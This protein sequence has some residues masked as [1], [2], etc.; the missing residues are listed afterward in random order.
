MEFQNYPVWN[1]EIKIFCSLLSHFYD[2][3]LTNKE[4]S[5]IKKNSNYTSNNQKENNSCF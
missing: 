1:R 2:A 5:T 4:A 3:S